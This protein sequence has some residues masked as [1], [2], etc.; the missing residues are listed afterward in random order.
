MSTV[1]L[2]PSLGIPTPGPYTVALTSTRK[3]SGNFS[4]AFTCWG[5][6]T[7]VLLHVWRS[8]DNLQRS[9]LSF[10]HVGSAIKLRLPGLQEPY[11]PA[12]PSCPPDSDLS[13]SFSF[14][15]KEQDKEGGRA[16]SWREASDNP[17]Y[18]G[19]PSSRTDCHSDACP[20][21]SL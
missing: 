13:V 16:R 8:D 21:L 20:Q 12:E 7:C 15:F 4:I 6:G 1:V 3:G 9:A 11:L 10:H 2:D 18:R 19:T 17:G 5:R 14:R